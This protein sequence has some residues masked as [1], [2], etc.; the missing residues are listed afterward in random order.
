MLI[1]LGLNIL[2]APRSAAIRFDAGQWE[3]AGRFQLWQPISVNDAHAILWQNIRLASTI[4]LAACY[5]N[6][7]GGQRQSCS[8]Q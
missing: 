5:L 2:T 1:L 7:K 8:A 4:G 3:K 6:G